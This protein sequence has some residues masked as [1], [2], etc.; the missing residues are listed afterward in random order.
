[1]SSNQAPIHSGYSAQTT[2]HE[3]LGNRDLRGAIALVTGGHA[4]LGLE[5]TRALAEAGATVLVGA[6]AP[7]AARAAIAGIPRV[8]ID[9]LDLLDPASIDGFAAR[10]VA[11][12]RPL[13]ML[14]N[15]AGIMATPLVRDPRGFES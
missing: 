5:T 2:A 3:A 13:H 15:N 7:D 14:V 6:R 9:A 8:E 10:F 11:S 12:G 1:M 4:G